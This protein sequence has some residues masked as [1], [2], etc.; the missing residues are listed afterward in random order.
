MDDEILAVL[1]DIRD[2]AKQTNV[3]LASVEDQ[4]KQTNVRLASLEGRVEFLEKRTSKGFEVLN[5]RL[6]SMNERLEDHVERLEVVARRQTESE[7]HLTTEVLSLATVTR[8]VRDFLQRW[9]A[10][11]RNHEERITALESRGK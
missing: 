9:G 11:H 5:E 8:E 2:E 3:R 10:D 7:M 4:A 1:K 6:E